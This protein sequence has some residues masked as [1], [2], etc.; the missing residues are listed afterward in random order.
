[1]NGETRTF[2]DVF[3]VIN[4]VF[5]TT[6]TFLMNIR[7][8]VYW[9][10][11]FTDILYTAIFAGKKINAVPNFTISFMRFNIYGRIDSSDYV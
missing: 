3:I 1:M 5:T 2:E 4:R 9:C 8:Q 11:V 10:N 6:F 7:S